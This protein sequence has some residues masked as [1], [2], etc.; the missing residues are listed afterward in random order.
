[1]VGTVAGD[2]E[3][4]GRVGDPSRHRPEA[5]NGRAVGPSPSPTCAAMPCA[6]HLAPHTTT[7]R[8][9]VLPPKP[10]LAPVVYPSAVLSLW[11]SIFW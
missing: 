3:A 10:K 7:P 6:A 9:D 2:G 8:H 4:D 1:M 5:R 11:W